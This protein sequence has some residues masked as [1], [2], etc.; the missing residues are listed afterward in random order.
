MPNWKMLH[1]IVPV[2]QKTPRELIDKADTSQIFDRKSQRQFNIM[3]NLD[4]Y[5]NLLL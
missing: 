4:I 3:W 5:V 1:I 2:A